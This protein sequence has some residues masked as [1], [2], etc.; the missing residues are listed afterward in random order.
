MFKS[1]RFICAA[2][3]FAAFAPVGSLAQDH[4]HVA[5]LDVSHG[6]PFVMVTLNGKG[7]FR[8]VIDT[9]TGGEAFVSKDLA[10]Q[11]A[12]PQ[13]GQMRLS[14]PSGKGSRRVPMVAIQS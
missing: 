11:L 10:S 12:L 8:F 3:I 2:L 5:R 6:K 13:I 4:E 7:P 9:G 14:D 1:S